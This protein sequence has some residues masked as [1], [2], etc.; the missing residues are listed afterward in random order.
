MAV[1]NPLLLRGRNLPC[2][3]GSQPKFLRSASLM[4][5]FCPPG[6]YGDGPYSSTSW[7]GDETYLN[8][9]GTSL[10][11]RPLWHTWRALDLQCLKHHIGVFYLQS[12]TWFSFFEYNLLILAR[13]LDIQNPNI[14]PMMFNITSSISAIRFMGKINWLISIIMDRV[15]PH[16]IVFIMLFF[17]LWNT[18]GKR[19]P[20]GINMIMFPNKI[21]IGTRKLT[22][23]N[24]IV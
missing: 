24:K 9:F 23:W 14:I 17:K 13:N 2:L 3:T 4:L 21:L 6:K 5:Y 19:K 11:V 1:V 10:F 16:S 8:N 22:L 7:N 20:M 15:I 12:L 18:I